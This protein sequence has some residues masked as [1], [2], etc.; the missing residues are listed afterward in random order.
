[1]RRRVVLFLVVPLAA[2]MLFGSFASARPAG[3]NTWAGVWKSDFGPLT[4]D[5]GGSGSYS[6]STPGTVSGSVTG[7]VDKGTWD[8]PATPGGVHK[9][10]TFTFTMSSGGQ[11]FTGV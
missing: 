1:M 2:L 9:S 10:G 8:Q 6:G 11:S 4:L 7:N 5:A 3:G